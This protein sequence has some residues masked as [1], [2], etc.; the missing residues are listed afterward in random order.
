MILSGVSYHENTNMP[1]VV[2]D[3]N[4]GLNQSEDGASH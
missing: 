3:V 4:L 2:N 1:I